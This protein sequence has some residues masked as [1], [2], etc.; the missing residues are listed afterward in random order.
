MASQSP[1]FTGSAFIVAVIL[2]VVMCCAWL[3][4]KFVYG[5]RRV[6]KAVDDLIKALGE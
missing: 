1:I 5:C 6:D 3:A 4:G 2:H